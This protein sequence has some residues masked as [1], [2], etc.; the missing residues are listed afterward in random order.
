MIK[1]AKG[2][3]TAERLVK[4]ETEIT[5]IKEKIDEHGRKLDAF[6]ES[7]DN[8]YASKLT[9]RI[10]FGL[11]ALLVIGVVTAILETVLR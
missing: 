2:D 1:M 5:Y 10:T 7:A 9:E 4:M 6:I 3:C 11:V 8:K